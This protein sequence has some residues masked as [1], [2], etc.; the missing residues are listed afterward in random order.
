MSDQ[1]RILDRGYRGY[2]GPRGGVA[3]AVKV[4]TRFSLG[5]VMGIGRGVW[6]KILPI[7]T[8][9]ISFLPAVVFVGMAALIPD[10][11]EEGLPTYGDYY[12][13]V[14]S[15]IIIFV[16][17][18]APELLCSDRRTRLIAL[19]LSSALDRMTYLLAKGLAVVVSLGIVTIGPPLLLLLAYTFQGTGPEDIAGFFDV[20]WRVVVAG[21]VVAGLLASLS[22][23]ISS[24][25]DRNGIASAAVILVLLLS[26]AV[27]SALVDGAGGPDELR[28]LDL[29]GLP[30]ELSARI[31][32]DTTPVWT[33]VTT[34]FLVVATIGWTMFF[35]GLV[36]WRYQKIEVTR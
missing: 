36:V 2:E 31:F 5:R 34:G 30:F 15:A 29:L 16:A 20:L 17:F 21:V 18:V 22:L 32:D 4:V 11:L 12:G 8:V 35:I 9:V 14:T 25:T 7:A 3:D 27:S 6:A 23:A 28:A 13:F 33:E 1:A 24:L 26:S 10:E 19:Y